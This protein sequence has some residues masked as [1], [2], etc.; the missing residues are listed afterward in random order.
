MD[1]SFWLAEIKAEA[2]PGKM[3]ST[4]WSHPNFCLYDLKFQY[5]TFYTFPCILH[6]FAE[7]ARF[8]K[9]YL[10]HKIFY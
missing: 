7:I 4:V 1:I 10:N 8:L 5:W 9:T 3:E 6:S 2:I